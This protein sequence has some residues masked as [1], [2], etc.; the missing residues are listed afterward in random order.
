M[1]SIEVV[2]ATPDRQ[3]SV[4]LDVEPGTTLGEAIERSRVQKLFPEVDLGACSTG[5]W[6][7]VQPRETVLKD[8]DRIEIY[9]PLE[10]DPKERRR[11]RARKT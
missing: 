9:R 2:F 8:G 1:L 3:E 7:R 11:Q 4:S 10:I 5:I 6:N